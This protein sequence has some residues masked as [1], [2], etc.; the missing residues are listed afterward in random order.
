MALMW[1]AIRSDGTW[2]SAGACSMIRHRLSAAALADGKP[3][4]AASPLMSWAAER[5]SASIAIQLLNSPE[6]PASAFSAR[7]TGSSRSDS[8]TRRNTLRSGLGC[9]ITWW[10][11]KDLTSSAAGLSFAM[12]VSLRSQLECDDSSSNRHPALALLFEHDLFGKPVPTFPDHALDCGPCLVEQ[13][14]LLHHFHLAADAALGADI[15]VGGV[16]AAVGSEIGLGLDEGP[17]AG[18]DIHDALVEPLGRDRLGQ[19]FGDAGVARHSHAALFG[20]TGQHDDRRVGVTLGFRLPDHLGE[21]EP[22]EDRHRPVG[23]DDIG[24]IVGVHF[25]RGRAVF[26]LIGLAR[27]ERMQQRPQDA[28]HVR[29]VVANQ[30]SQLVE[31]DAI[32]GPAPRAYRAKRYT[33]R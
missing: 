13:R 10:S 19:E 6:R 8:G 11:A 4:V 21:F 17:R 3:N 14:G 16:A 15:G 2:S 28:A 31:V 23:D 25:E 27:A 20:V 5:R 30:K 7:P 1:C 22:V 29:I 12:M 18:D 33:P 24:D 26:G 9:V 32:H